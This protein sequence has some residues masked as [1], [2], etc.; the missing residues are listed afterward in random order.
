MENKAYTNIASIKYCV[1]ISHT[2][3]KVK[4]QKL[5]EIQRNVVVNIFDVF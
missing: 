1:S 5:S 3:K 4:L 2:I